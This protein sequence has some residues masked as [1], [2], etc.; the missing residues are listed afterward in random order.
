MNDVTETKVKDSTPERGTLSYGPPDRERRESRDTAATQLHRIAA[1]MGDFG[2][3]LHVW[4]DTYGGSKGADLVFS[5]PMY[6]LR[7]HVDFSLDKLSEMA[8]NASLIARYPRMHEALE[9]LGELPALQIDRDTGTADEGRSKLKIF[10]IVKPSG[11]V[12]FVNDFAENLQ[13]RGS[14]KSGGDFEPTPAE[15]GMIIGRLND[16]MQR[17]AELEV[18]WDVLLEGEGP[19]VASID[20]ILFTEADSTFAFAKKMFYAAERCIRGTIANPPSEYWKAMSSRPARA[21]VADHHPSL[22]SV[23]AR[24]AAEATTI[25]EAIQEMAESEVVWPGTGTRFRPDQ[26]KSKNGE[27]IEFGDVVIDTSTGNTGGVVIGIG[28]R[29]VLLAEYYED[30]PRGECDVTNASDCV[31]VARN[32]PLPTRVTS[33]VALRPDESATPTSFTDERSVDVDGQPIR[34]GD[35]VEGLTV[36][37]CCG[38]VCG[39]FGDVCV[40][41]NDFNDGDATPGE[42]LYANNSEVRVLKPASS[43]AEAVAAARQRGEKAR[44]ERQSREQA[45][46]TPVPVDPAANRIESLT[47]ANAE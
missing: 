19:E 18:A 33:E 20:S 9:A 47:T 39:V 21:T 40:Y 6:E 17:L 43:V 25:T 22:E 26:C 38:I 8:G 27:Q 24:G 44:R 34:A 30:E 4:C 13:N 23:K 37:D 2:A 36:H 42:F 11:M 10:A 28:G 5:E 41:V 15:Q 1:T 16:V 7:N 12:N 3:A 32:H 14:W 29:Y 35:R 31:I 46:E 45:N